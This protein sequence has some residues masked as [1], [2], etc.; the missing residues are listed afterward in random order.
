MKS[1]QQIHRV[2]DRL[3][4]QHHRGGRH[5]NADERINRHGRRQS[6]GLPQNLRPLRLGIAREIGNV[7]RDCRPKSHHPGQ[8]RNEKAQ[9]LTGGL[10][11]TRAVEH[12]PETARFASNPP[13]QQQA[14]AQHERRAHAF[15]KLDGFN[16]APDHR[17][18]Q[19]PEREETDPLT[20]RMCGACGNTMA[21]ME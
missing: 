20:G 9:K 5:R 7:Q 21:S 4:E 19:Q 14:D 11:F 6:Q 15:Q 12:G 8:D 16:S 13:E 17:H 10:K 1:H 3:S 18:V 2:P